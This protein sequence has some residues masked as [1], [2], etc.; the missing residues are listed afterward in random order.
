MCVHGERAGGNEE[1]AYGHESALTHRVGHACEHGRETSDQQ[2][3][4]DGHES[5]YRQGDRGERYRSAEARHTER[6]RQA[7]Q[8][9]IP[10]IVLCIAVDLSCDADTSPA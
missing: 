1:K 7:G 2:R 10:E 6:M 4:L 3:F 5:G 9:Q 8:A